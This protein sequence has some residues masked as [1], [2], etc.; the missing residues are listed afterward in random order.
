MQQF[1]RSAPDCINTIVPAHLEGECQVHD[2][3]DRNLEKAHHVVKQAALVE[4]TYIRV[5]QSNDVIKVN[6]FGQ[7]LLELQP[8]TVQDLG[9]KKAGLWFEIYNQQV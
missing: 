8:D 4:L 2:L 3:G 6:G 9:R 7:G 5:M 1:E